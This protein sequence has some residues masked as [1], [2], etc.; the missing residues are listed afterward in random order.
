[1]RAPGAQPLCAV[2]AILLL[3][4]DGSPPLDQLMS[5]LAQ[6]RHGEVQFTEEKYLSLFKQPL[7][8][9]GQLI[10]DAP[11]HLEERTTTPRPQ[12]L[13]LDHGVLSIH[14]GSHARTLRLADYPQLAPLIDSILSTLSGDRAA[15]ERL[16]EVQ[17]AGTLDHW[18][19]HLN[20]HDAQVAASLTRIDLSGERDSIR[21]VQVQQHDGDRSIM[22]IAQQE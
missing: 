7:R 15:L 14:S 11:D 13:I 22:H 6:R 3:A 16:F 10:Y 17:F 9:A 5:L 8:S 18:Q 1:M 4:A 2:V 21:E 12:S 20:P 19:L